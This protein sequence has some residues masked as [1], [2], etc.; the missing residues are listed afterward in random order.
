MDE[1]KVPLRRVVVELV[2]LLEGEVDRVDV[3]LASNAAVDMQFIIE[4]AVGSDLDADGRKKSWD[5][6]RCHDHIT[7]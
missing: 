5:R 2:E 4:L 3:D 6:R 7:E 1:I